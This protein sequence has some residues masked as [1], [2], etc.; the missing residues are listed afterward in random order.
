MPIEA[1]RHRNVPLR[2]GRYFANIVGHQPAWV[3]HTMASGSLDGQAPATSSKGVGEV[4]PEVKAGMATF[5]DLTQGGLF[6]LLGHYKKPLVIE[7]MDAGGGTV[8]VVDQNKTEKRT[9]SSAP[10]KLAPGEYLK[11]TGAASAGFL[12][13]IDG[14]KIL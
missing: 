1:D 6:T 9:I 10:H 12:V 4:D 8:K 2:S 11:V 7:D 3:Y 14:E 13:R 5:K